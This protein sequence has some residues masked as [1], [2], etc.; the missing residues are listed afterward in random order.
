MVQRSK[1]FLP[2]LEWIFTPIGCNPYDEIAAEFP[3]QLLAPR[4]LCRFIWCLKVLLRGK[5]I[6][7]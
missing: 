5:N 3:W 7:M 2:A 4:N 6:H 1:L